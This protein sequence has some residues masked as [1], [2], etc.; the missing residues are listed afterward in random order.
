M[1]V[2][3]RFPTRSLFNEHKEIRRQ[4]REAQRPDPLEEA[5]RRAIEHER[6]WYGRPEAVIREEM[7]RAV[8][9][10]HPDGV[11]W[12]EWRRTWRKAR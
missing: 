8:R 7:E 4:L 11:T 3:G 5:R 12:P 1:E 10:R 6:E 2:S 9:R